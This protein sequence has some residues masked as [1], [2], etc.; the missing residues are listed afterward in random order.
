[1]LLYEKYKKQTDEKFIIAQIL[2]RKNEKDHA[3]EQKLFKSYIAAEQTR[4]TVEYR[5]LR[6]LGATNRAFA[7]LL[8]FFLL[9]AFERWLRRFTFGSM[10]RS[11]LNT[12]KREKRVS[13]VIARQLYRNVSAGISVLS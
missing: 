6:R 8:A 2:I 9:T 1:M 13:A 10:I 5:L 12:R 4:K 11:A 3:K 7:F